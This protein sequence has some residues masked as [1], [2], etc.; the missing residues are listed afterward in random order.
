MI[1][2]FRDMQVWEDSMN[3]AVDI[4]EIS[5]TFPK[6]EDYSLTSQIRRSATSI[7]ANIAEAFGRFHTKDKMNFYYFARGSVT[8]TQ[9]HLIYSSN[10]IISL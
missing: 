10:Y 9:S 1:K 4:F 7:S 5:N 2:S 8:E 6:K 3:I